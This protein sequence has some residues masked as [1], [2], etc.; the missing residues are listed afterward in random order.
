MYGARARWW[1]A[2]A[3]RSLALD[4]AAGEPRLHEPLPEGPDEHERDRG[5]ERR[6]REEA[7]PGAEVPA[8]EDV[9]ADGHRIQL[10]ILVHER[11]HEVLVEGRHE[12]EQE[13]DREHR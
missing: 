4:G 12:V 10:R 8:D 7:V 3:R 5:E 2:A 11:G 13:Q 6:R 9:H 1:M